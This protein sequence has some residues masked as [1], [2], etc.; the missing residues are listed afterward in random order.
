M[1]TLYL[2]NSKT[3]PNSGYLASLRSAQI[4]RCRSGLQI[5]ANR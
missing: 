4:P 2:E 1:S 3:S 5:P